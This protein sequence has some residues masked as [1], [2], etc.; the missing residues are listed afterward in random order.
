MTVI[1]S[2][3]IV[4]AN[5]AAYRV[6]GIA[7]MR[8]KL[9]DRIADQIS[10]AEALEAGKSC[11]RV[12]YRRVRDLEN[13]EISEVPVRTRIRPWWVNDSDGG[14]LVWIKYGNQA[15]ELQ[16]GKS[17]IKV[18]SSTELVEVFKSVA[19]AVRAGELDTAIVAAVGTFKARFSK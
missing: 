12:K 16:K 14:M 4:S 6:R 1:S 13:D 5:P 10:L 11:Q 8:Q 15:L 2:L 19:T 18:Q 17:A 3:T 7:A 9:L